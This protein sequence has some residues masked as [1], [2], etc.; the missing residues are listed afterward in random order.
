MA[1]IDISSIYLNELSDDILDAETEKILLEKAQ[2][3]N[4]AAREELI[5]A[6]LRLVV[7][8]AKKYN[9]QNASLSFLD[10][11]QEGNIGLMTAID[12]YD[13]SSSYRFST[14]AYYWIKSAITRALSQQSENIR[15]PSHIVEKINR[16]KKIVTG[17]MQK[18]NS[19]S[20][21]EA[22]AE[23]GITLEELKKIKSYMNDMVSLDS[24]M[25]EDNED[26]FGDFVEDEESGIQ[27]K[28]EK[29]EMCQKID[30]VLSTLPDKESD[31]LKM[32][33]GIGYIKPLTLD[34]IAKKIG[35]SKERVRQVEKCA[36]KKMRNPVRA[37]I[38]KDY[39]A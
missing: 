32:R 26:S 4:K 11:I 36:L 8:I 7:F 24:P 21:E 6:N 30:K 2:S 5:K 23:M 18:Y 20:D 25:S 28:Y 34:E 15:V 17:M 9:S 38:L 10:L 13:L 37:S 14:Y 29:K 19:F 27:E 39:V 16:Y 3:G 31:I 12:K 35:L 22:A 33:F 1:D